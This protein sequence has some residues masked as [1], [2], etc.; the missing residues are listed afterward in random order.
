M[1]ESGVADHPP[2][3]VW[4]YV[5][6]FTDSGVVVYPQCGT[7]CCRWL[8]SMLRFTQVFCLVPHVAVDRVGCCSSPKFCLVPHAAVDW[9]RCC[10]SPKFCLVPHAAV[11]WIGCCSSAPVC[12]WVPVVIEGVEEDGEGKEEEED[13]EG[14]PAQV[15]LPGVLVD[16]LQHGDTQEQT[17]TKTVRGNCRWHSTQITANTRQSTARINGANQ[18]ISTLTADS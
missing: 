15:G 8:N 17:W 13:D 11:D 7:A 6:P 18:V 1:I 4:Y 14:N 9:I 5:L 10:S 12:N 16:V 3:S 2:S